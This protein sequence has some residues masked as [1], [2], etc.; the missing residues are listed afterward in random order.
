MAI[1]FMQ[2]NLDR[3]LT[4]GEIAAAAVSS[5]RSLRRQFQRFTGQSPVAFHRRMRLEATHRA[6]CDNPAKADITTAATMHGFSHLSHFADQYQ[7]RFGEPPSATLG[8]FR[9]RGL[10]QPLLTIREPVNLIV[11][12]FICSD[13]E[14]GHATFA[15]IMTDRVIAALSRTR[16]INVLSPDSNLPVTRNMLPCAQYAVRGRVQYIGGN[17]QAIIRLIDITTSRQVWGNAF[18]G[19][20]ESA[21]EL[22]QRVS[23]TVASALPACLRNTDVARGKMAERNPVAVRHGMQAFHAILEMTQSANGRALEHLD[24]AQS[25]DPA[26]AFARALAAWCH[27][28]RAACCFGDTIEIDRDKARRL[29]TLTL[30]MDNEDPLVL[31]VLGH[32]STIFAD[33]D[34]GSLLIEK[35]LA[36]DPGCLLAWQRRGWL[37][38]YRGSDGALADFDRALALNPQG[39]ERFNTMLGI[40]QAHFLAGNYEEAANWAAQCLRERPRET[41]ARRIAVVAQVRCGQL[42][43]GRQ[44][45]ALLR[46]Q[47]P[48][49]TVG[50]I[51]NALPT[52]PAEFLARQAEALESAGLRA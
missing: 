4:A 47:Y 45:I 26:F 43:A 31:A 29:T 7:R 20:A 10:P 38:V 25:I 30:T 11:L 35:C 52:M 33:L 44:G 2:R 49:I 22:Q 15:E 27:A 46:R 16:W 24:R 8:A 6:L 36:I 23:E 3:P 14:S 12:P 17:V 51:V 5:E 28:Q 37:G 39:P 18:E 41:W 13:S 32:A 40:S 1:N 48:D 9:E 42:A 19:A 21:M 50:T 34:L